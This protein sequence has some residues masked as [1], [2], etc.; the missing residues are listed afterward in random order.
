MDDLQLLASMAATVNLIGQS[1]PRVGKG[2]FPF[3]WAARS[4]G[5]QATLGQ[6]SS[7]LGISLPRC[8]NLA[9]RLEEEGYIKRSND[10]CDKRICYVEVTE[11]G[12]EFFQNGCKMWLRFIADYR[13][14]I[15]EENFENLLKIME[16]TKEY[17]RE[18]CAQ[19]GAENNA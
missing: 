2:M 15:G 9:K 10:P 16:L 13:K 7:I 19:G 1:L 18:E 14:R 4:R 3:V 12:E 17:L 11:E 8:S 6:L 5:G